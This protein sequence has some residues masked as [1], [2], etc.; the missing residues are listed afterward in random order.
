MFDCDTV[1]SIVK[2]EYKVNIYLPNDM[3]ILEVKSLFNE[4][5][6]VKVV[7]NTIIDTIG[8]GDV[9]VYYLESE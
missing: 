1:K 8:Y 3:H 5:S 7:G 2:G 4:S 9:R 6:T